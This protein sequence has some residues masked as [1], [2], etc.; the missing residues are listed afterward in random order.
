MFKGVPHCENTLLDPFYPFYSSPLPLYLPPCTFKQISLHT[1]ISSTFTDGRFYDIV[2]AL[3]IPFP[4]CPSLRSIESSTNTN[5]LYIWVCEWSCL[6]M[7]ICLSFRS[8]FHVWEKTWDLCLSE[9]GLLHLIGN[10]VR[11][12]FKLHSLWLSKISWCIYTA[13]SWSTHQL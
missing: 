5:M 1:L 10:Y 3:T 2:D 11:F 4:F 9:L 7:Y 6:F 13:F 12:S 8:V